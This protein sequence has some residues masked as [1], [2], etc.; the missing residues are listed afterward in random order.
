MQYNIQSH[1]AFGITCCSCP[2]KT[3]RRIVQQNCAMGITCAWVKSLRFDA[4]TKQAKSRHSLTR[5]IKNS[6]YARVVPWPHSNLASLQIMHCNTCI[7][8][9][10]SNCFLLLGNAGIDIRKQW[11]NMANTQ[12]WECKKL[13]TACWLAISHDNI[14]ASFAKVAAL[15][16][17]QSLMWAHGPQCPKLVNATGRSDRSGTWSCA[18]G[19]NTVFCQ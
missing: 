1:S 7:S 2:S 3:V 6:K 16:V 19:S 15:S 17:P 11:Q 9:V 5:S 18:N 12:H 10:H 13:P 8:R 14:L 4:I